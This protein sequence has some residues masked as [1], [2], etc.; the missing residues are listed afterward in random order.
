MLL[1]S[2][3]PTIKMRGDSDVHGLFEQIL[4]QTLELASL[5][6]LLLAY[7]IPIKFAHPPPNILFY[8]KMMTLLMFRGYCLQILLCILL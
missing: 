8:I 5:F 6:I 4:N 3:L 1:K 2:S 7:F